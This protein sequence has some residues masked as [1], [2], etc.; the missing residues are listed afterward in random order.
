MSA[1]HGEQALWGA[2]LLSTVQDA[3]EGVSAANSRHPSVAARITETKAARRYLTTYSED[4]ATVCSLAG[5]DIDFIIQHMRRLIAEA[6]PVEVLVRRRTKKVA[7]P[8]LIDGEFVSRTEL[9]ARMGVS[10]ATIGNWLAQLREAEVDALAVGPK[11]N[12]G[13]TTKLTSR[14]LNCHEAFLT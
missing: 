7:Q 3:L 4:L 1:R 6:P 12:L 8:V 14:S 13:K 2:V 5:F 11:L 9:A 10:Y